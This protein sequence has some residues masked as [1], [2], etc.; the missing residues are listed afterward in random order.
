VILGRA[1]RGQAAVEFVLC[2]PIVALGF[3]VL[4]EIGLLVGDH[5]RLW[6]A[7][8]EG[9]RIAVVDSDPDEIRGAAEQAGLSP[10]TVDVDPEFADRSTGEPLTVTLRYKPSGHL[11]LLGELIDGRTLTSSATMRIEQP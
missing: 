1:E 8:R 10:L 9:A 7:A 5:V 2:L 4:I 6:H 3:G 11:P